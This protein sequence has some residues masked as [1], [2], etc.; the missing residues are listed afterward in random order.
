M[1]VYEVLEKSISISYV[2]NGFVLYKGDF[3]FIKPDFC[4][5]RNPEKKELFCKPYLKKD[6]L[7]KIYYRKFVKFVD[8]GDDI[9]EWTWIDNINIVDPLIN[10]K[11]IDIED[12]TYLKD[13][14][15]QWVRENKLNFLLNN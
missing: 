2:D 15:L 7:V 5:I 10:D 1:K 4:W 11:I 6:L 3:I 12:N 9:Y 8:K 14:T 13:V